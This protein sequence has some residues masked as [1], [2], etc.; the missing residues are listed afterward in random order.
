MDNQSA[1]QT[2]KIVTH[3]FSANVAVFREDNQ[4][5]LKHFFRGLASGAYHD[6]TSHSLHL[7]LSDHTIIKDSVAEPNSR[8]RN[9]D[10]TLVLITEVKSKKKNTDISRIKEDD[11]EE[12]GYNGWLEGIEH[13][14][15][16]IINQQ[17]GGDS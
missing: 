11:I 9:G 15:M 2:T 17:Q 13:K 7:D 6:C 8:V 1:V 12:W 10:P 4:Q 16:N 14:V 3:I 5:V